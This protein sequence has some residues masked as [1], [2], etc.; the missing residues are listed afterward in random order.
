MVHRFFNRQAWTGLILLSA[1]ADP[2]APPDPLFRPDPA[3]KSRYTVDQSQD[4]IDEGILPYALYPLDPDRSVL[5]PMKQNLAQTFTAGVTGRMDYVYLPI[6][7]AEGVNFRL[8]IRAG[9]P[10]GALLY[11]RQY[12]PSKPFADGAFLSM[13]I[14]GGVSVTASSVYALVLSSFPVSGSDFSCSI[15]AGPLGDPYAGGAGYQNNP[16]FPLN[17]WTPIGDFGRDDLPF[18]TL[19]R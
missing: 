12:N 16:G 6:A 8:Q 2:A 17:Y 7:C 5:L 11:D 1:C 4:V 14:Y 18:V 9:D 10:D 19:V 3:D 13:Q 15:I